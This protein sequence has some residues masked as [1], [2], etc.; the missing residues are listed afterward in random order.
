MSALA[1]TDHDAVYHAIPFAREAVDVG[2]HP[3]LGAELTL[4]DGGHLTVL[5]KN[6]AGWSNLCQLISLGRANA[7]KGKSRLRR[8]D[9][10]EYTPGLIAL[11]GCRNGIVS[12][13]LLRGEFMLAQQELAWLY[14]GFGKDLWLELQHHLLPDD[15]SLI[16]QL[17]KLADPF[18]IAPVA[19]NNV[20]YATRDTHD[21]RQLLVAIRHHHKISDI[22]ERLH[23]NSEYYLKSYQEMAVL[24]GE[25]P[26]ALQNTLVIAEQCTYLPPAEPQPF[27]LYPIPADTT[28]DTYLR[29]LCEAAL[30]RKYQMHSER[31]LAQLDYELGVVHR[32]GLDN[33]FLVVW[34]ICRYARSQNILH[35]ARGSACNSLMTYLLDIS[36]VDPIA[37]DLVFE[38]FLSDERNEPPDIDMDFPSAGDER[39]SIIQ[40]IY[41]RYGS[42]HV[43]M[44]CTYSRYDLRGALRDA[45]KALGIPTQKLDRV[46]KRLDR[47]THTIQD[48]PE[49][50]ELAQKGEIWQQLQYF[51]QLLLG[52]PRHLSIHNGGMVLTQSPLTSRLP[53][54]PAK[55]AGRTVV[56][57]DKDYLEMAGLVKLDILGLYMLSVI[58]TVMQWVNAITGQAIVWDDIPPDDENIYAMLAKGDTIGI[59]QLESRAQSHVLPRLKPRCFHDIIV[60]ISL[61]R[62][63]PIL[64]NMKEPYLRRRAGQEPVIY[65]H[66]SLE[67]ALHETLGVILFQEQV[68]KVASHFSGLSAGTCERLRRAFGK[69]HIDITP[70][71]HAFWNGARQKGASDETIQ[72]VWDLLKSFGGYAFAK[73]HACAFAVLV[74]R[75]AYLKL[76]YPAAFYAG[77]LSHQPM[78]FWPPRVLI[79]DAR[80]HGVRVLNVDVN[81]SDV[82]CIAHQNEVRLGIAYVKGLGKRWAQQI[83]EQRGD[84]PFTGLADFCRRTQLPRA[85]IANVIMAGAMDEWGE[86]RRL[87]WELHHWDYQEGRFLLQLGENNIHLAPLSELEKHL[88]ELEI[89]KLSVR[90]HFISHYRAALRS[91]GILDSRSAGRC[92][93][94]RRVTIAGEIAVHQAPPTARGV[95]F[96]TLEDEFGLCN[97]LVHPTIYPSCRA[98]LRDSRF[99]AATG[100]IQ[101]REGA[102]H[103]VVTL[104]VSLFRPEDLPVEYAH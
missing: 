33:Y 11:S 73:S 48:S 7:P 23:P 78:G 99:V 13:A 103:L 97:L 35:Q 36:P 22:P 100:T 39:E 46:I 15:P 98:A 6:E 66:P 31:I 42:D 65:P 87:L 57:W 93:G 3:I 25:L 60:S 63:G 101:R 89:L 28:P 92:P 34:D 54:E 75:S 14:D 20:H 55:M 43:A 21:L 50:S 88:W 32:A 18:A 5:V 83:V 8:R 56:Q 68:I 85:L 40:Y 59:F 81:A 58:T 17:L 82:Q 91:Q 84:M 80:R 27:P 76:Y 61:I 38:R 26:Q 44:A 45:G 67:K 95:H 41:Q 96:L 10:M 102:I 79:G 64:G 30:P 29:T 47:R 104:V 51:A 90:E 77:L 74:Y 94:G 72:Y 2:I 4:E 49:L 12:R 71:Q 24:F 86:R 53:V 16:Q 9:L 69:R 62:P 37:H 19:T 70:L 52:I 1:L